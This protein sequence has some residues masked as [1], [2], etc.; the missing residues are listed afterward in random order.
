[1]RTPGTKRTASSRTSPMRIPENTWP[2]QGKISNTKTRKYLMALCLSADQALQATHRR[3]QIPIAQLPNARAQQPAVRV[4]LQI[5]SLL[6][7]I[8][9]ELLEPAES[10][11][12]FEPHKL[13]PRLVAVQEHNVIDHATISR[14]D[15]GQPLG[16]HLE[17]DLAI[18]PLG[19]VP[20]LQLGE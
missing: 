17:A 4:A 14:R 19:R 16:E 3:V 9:T 20:V 11:F 1:M 5:S 10:G 15:A 12:G 18:R 13:W 7:A 6:G 8:A 2:A